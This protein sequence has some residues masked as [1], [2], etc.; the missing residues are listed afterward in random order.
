MKKYF[1]QKIVDEDMIGRYNRMDKELRCCLCGHTFIP[2]EQVNL[3][4]NNSWRDGRPTGM[5]NPLICDDC[6][7][8]DVLDRWAEHCKVAAEKFWWMRNS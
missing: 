5:F 2:G 6:D 1:F 7:G 8:E 4:N 3:L